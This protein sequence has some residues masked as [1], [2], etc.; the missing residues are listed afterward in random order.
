MLHQRLPDANELS[1]AFYS[2]GGSLSRGTL[3]TMM[4]SIHEGGAIRRDGRIVRGASPR[5]HNATSSD[6]AAG[7]PSILS[8]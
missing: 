2:R 1:L 4:E 7:R 8:S 5:S 6:A 3:K